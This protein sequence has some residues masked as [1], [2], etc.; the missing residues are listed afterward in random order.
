MNL[1]VENLTKQFGNQLSL[2]NVTF[3]LKDGEIV[4]LLGP[5]GAGKST[6]MKMLTGY[7]NPTS[8]SVYV[9]NRLLSEHKMSIQQQTGYLPEHNPLYT[10]MFVREYLQFIAAI[11]QIDKTEV[12]NV[13]HKV[14]LTPEVHKKIHQLSKGYR[15][16]VGLAAAI[17]HNPSILILDEPTTGLDPNQIQEI[18]QLIKDLGKDRIV[19]FSSHILQ[20]VEAVCDRVIILH[21][22]KMLQDLRLNQMRSTEQQLIEVE[23]DLRV[24]EQFLKTLPNLIKVE[25]VFDTTW[26]LTFETHEDMRP[27]L[28][29]F[30]Q[31]NGLRALKIISKNKSLA[32]L[33]KE[34]TTN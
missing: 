14:G 8:G 9:N 20:E 3:E 13:I 16:R 12:E 31:L 33:F 34:L 2:N 18:R 19:L 17:L 28:V 1:R 15:Q 7:L 10:E 6:L 32:N 24:E 30:A 27:V 21:K 4:G 5:N 23:F 26:E 29:D 11:H 22:G 25:N